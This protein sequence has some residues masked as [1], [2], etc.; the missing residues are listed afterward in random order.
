MQNPS[1]ILNGVEIAEKNKED[2]F[3]ILRELVSFNTEVGS[4]YEEIQQFIAKKLSEIGAEVDIW[5]PDFEILRK[6]QWFTTPVEYYPEGFKDKPIVVGRLHGTGGGRSL[7]FNGHV[8][9]VTPG[10]L[11]LWTSDPWA[12]SIRDGKMFGRGVIDCKGGLAAAIQAM[13]AI[14]KAGIK[15]KGDVLLESVFDEEIGGTG[16]L[17]TILKGY[18]ADAA[19]VTEPTHKRVVIA[20]PGVMWFRVTVNGKSAH[21]ANLWEGVNSI[22]KAL[23]IHKALCDYGE[24]RMQFMRHPLFEDFPIH[25]TF[26]PGTFRAGGYPSSVPDQTI[27]EYRIGLVPGEQNEE[28]L[29]EI[30]SVIKAEA[31][32]DIWLK[33]HP[34]ELSLFG[35]YGLPFELDRKEKIIDCVSSCYKYVY[36]Q[37]PPLTGA[38]A[39]NDSW[40]LNC[41]GKMPTLTLG[42][43]GGK[44]H[45]NDEFI[46][47]DDYQSL[48]KIFVATMIAWCC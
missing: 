22:E 48:I 6:S 7:I 36:G 3:R 17:A 43:N 47:L 35:W 25:A 30:K 34:P 45:Q 44:H 16:T 26:N 42:N 8:E 4:P 33:V 23:K 46:I 19:I 20:R 39:N 5:E 1:M 2:S 28:V 14:S 12:G 18:S 11:E 24:S 32:K 29:E 40:L 13:K 10:P 21:A 41:I 27:L 15:L 9:V 37:L 38:T 31:V